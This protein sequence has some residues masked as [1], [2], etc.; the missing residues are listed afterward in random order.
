MLTM[1]PRINSCGHTYSASG[2]HGWFQSAVS[3][4]LN[5]LDSLYPHIPRAFFSETKPAIF[6][7]ERLVDLRLRTHLFRPKYNCPYCTQ[8]MRGAPVMCLNFS[9]LG[10]KIRELAG[11]KTEEKG[12]AE[13]PCDFSDYFMFFNHRG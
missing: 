3:A 4:Q 10:Q 7:R 6:D 11:S 12:G 9:E 2:L 8:P 13:F 5:E 1:P